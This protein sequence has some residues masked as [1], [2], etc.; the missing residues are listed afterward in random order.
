M[1]DK[2]N[3]RLTTGQTLIQQVVVQAWMK[4][5]WGGGGRQSSCLNTNLPRLA[6]P[7]SIIERFYFGVNIVIPELYL[8][9]AFLTVSKLPEHGR[10]LTQ[11]S[12]CPL[13]C[14]ETVWVGRARG[15]LMN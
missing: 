3:R 2:I 10:P 14:A 9:G 7:N 8:S 11:G 6:L 13:C 5:F 1:P 12:G 4:L 15:K